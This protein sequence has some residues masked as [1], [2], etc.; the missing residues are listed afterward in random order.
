MG[1]KAK[2]P[3]QTHTESQD[4]RAWPRVNAVGITVT[5]GKLPPPEEH[6]DISDQQWITRYIASS[7]SRALSAPLPLPRVRVAQFGAK[8]SR[9]I[10]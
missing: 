2:L 5:M 3:G 7:S 9:F 10:P 6:S 4:F 1:Q 8:A